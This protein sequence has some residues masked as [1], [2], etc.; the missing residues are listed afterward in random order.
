VRFD[1]N[2]DRADPLF[3]VINLGPRNRQGLWKYVDVGYV[4]VHARHTNIRKD[5]IWW[6]GSEEV[7]LDIP[8]DQY[9]VVPDDA[10]TVLLAIVFG[11]ILICVFA[12]VCI[13]RK[14]SKNKNARRREKAAQD[15]KDTMNKVCI[16]VLNRALWFA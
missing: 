11:S 16:C 13:K 6:A 1:E 2:G 5:E 12:A 4:G 9:E 10:N 15:A 7:G 8:A 3:T 14:L